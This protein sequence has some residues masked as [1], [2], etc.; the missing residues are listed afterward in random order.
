VE[1]RRQKREENIAKRRNLNI[2][3]DAD[4]DDETGNADEPGVCT[5]AIILLVVLTDAQLLAH[6]GH[7]EERLLR[8]SGV[9]ARFVV[10]FFLRWDLTIILDATVKFRKLL[11]KEKNAPIDQVIQC[12]VIPRFV[13]FLQGGH[14]MLQVRTI[15]LFMSQTLMSVS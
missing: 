4:S 6:R 5:C 12:G 7:G 1:I 11:S 8:Q 15:I 9:A 2:T 14:S 10:F 13:Q 3:G